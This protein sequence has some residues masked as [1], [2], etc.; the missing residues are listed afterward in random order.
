[1]ATKAATWRDLDVSFDRN[2][3]TGDVATVVDVQ[4]ILQHIKQLV[5]LEAYDI[6]FRPDLACGLPF[7]E[8][9]LFSDQVTNAANF[10]VQSLIQALEPRVRLL[11]LNV[12]FNPD[13]NAFTVAG[14][15]QVVAT[16][17]II[18]FEQILQ[19]FR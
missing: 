10:A 14:K 7:Y 18:P 1:M 17:Q 3:I 19:R 2:P 16:G 11:S 15:V 4:A 9:E 5:S 6:P 12:T 8:F 13:G